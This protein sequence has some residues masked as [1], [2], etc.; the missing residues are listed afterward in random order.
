MAGFQVSAE[1]L[2]TPTTTGTYAGIPFFEDRSAPEM[3]DS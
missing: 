1:G 3:A 2:V